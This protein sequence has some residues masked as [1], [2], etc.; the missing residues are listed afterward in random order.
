L[1]C[2]RVAP[3][4]IEEAIRK[5]PLKLS[6]RTICAVVAVAILVGCHAAA[7]L[8]PQQTEGKHLYDVGCAHC[9][10]EN[11]LHLK[12]VPPDLRGLFERTALPDGAPATD[13]EVER[14]LMSGKGTMPSFAYQMTREQMEAVI[15]YLHTG[16]PDQHHL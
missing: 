13:A 6:R 11:D 9:H 10:E 4:A 15:A 1:N 2:N 7:H 3:L 8:T 16:L 14:I 5:V 12:K